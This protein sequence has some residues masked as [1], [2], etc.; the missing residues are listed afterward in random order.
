MQIKKLN[1]YAFY[2]KAPSIAQGMSSLNL[3]STSSVVQS[4]SR[5]A[6]IFR[7]N[8]RT[9]NEYLDVL[10]QSKWIDFPYAGN[11]DQR[12]L[13][14]IKMCFVESNLQIY[15]GDLASKIIMMQSCLRIK[16]AFMHLLANSI[17]ESRYLGKWMIMDRLAFD[18]LRCLM[19]SWKCFKWSKL[20]KQHEIGWCNMSSSPHLL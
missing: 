12:L 15:E 4:N 7:L 9:G 8:L 1:S 6:E 17:S 14:A 16:L 13:L 3:W 20:I 5:G 19:L 18:R 2:W 10:H 11:A